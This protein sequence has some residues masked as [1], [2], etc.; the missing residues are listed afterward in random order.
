VNSVEA[1]AAVW[2]ELVAAHRLARQ[3]PAGTD[4]GPLR[5]AYR[6]GVLAI[7]TGMTGQEPDVVIE[8]LDANS[9]EAVAA[10]WDE[11][12][13]AHRLVRQAAGTDWGPLRTAYRDGAL[14]IYTGM[15]GQEP[16]V[17]IEQLDEAISREQAQ[18]TLF[19]RDV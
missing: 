18:A 12:V 5:T 14:A 11:L 4:W 7:Y 2:D 16:D 3:A 8:Q 9:V 19:G 10:V 1:V 15:T 6:D 17:V 13:A